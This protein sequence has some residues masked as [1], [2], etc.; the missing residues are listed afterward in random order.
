LYPEIVGVICARQTER[1]SLV[2]SDL[3]CKTLFIDGVDIKRWVGE[4]K[5]KPGGALVGIFVVA[6][7]FTDIPLKS[8]Y[9][10]VHPTELD[11]LAHFLLTVN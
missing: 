4:G 1:K 2:L 9:G 7:G 5:I 10:E 3:F 6:I 11:R 8:V